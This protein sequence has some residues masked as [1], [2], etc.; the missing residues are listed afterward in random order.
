MPNVK[1]AS[2]REGPLAA[3]FRK[4]AEDTGAKPEE[5]QPALSAPKP[6]RQPKQPRRQEAPAQE[7]RL[8]D[9]AQAD[10]AS[11]RTV[12]SP[13]ERLR[14]AFAADIP[15]NVLEPPPASRPPPAADD[16]RCLRALRAGQ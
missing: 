1:R 11:A 4:T 5:E 9:E 13:Q 2:M 15:Q 8:A 10:E 3:L 16:P 7:H 14:H 6:P 12:P